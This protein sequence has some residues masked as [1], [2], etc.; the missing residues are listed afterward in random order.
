MLPAPTI[1]RSLTRPTINKLGVPHS[2]SVIVLCGTVI[3][4]MWLG[5]SRI[6]YYFVL[7]PIEFVAMRAL[8]EWD[9]NFWR[10]FKLWW[11]TKFKAK[12]KTIRIWG[13]S[14]LAA[15][16]CGVADDAKDVAGAI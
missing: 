2:L 16:P 9:P 12:L 7:L 13:G 11:R 4:V 5:N 1:F 10:I 8:V 15:L 3:A 6:G 14:Y